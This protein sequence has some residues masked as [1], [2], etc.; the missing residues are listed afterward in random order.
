MASTSATISLTSSNFD[1]VAEGAGFVTTTAAGSGTNQV[2]VP[3][4]ANAAAR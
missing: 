1:T 2:A 4:F 3:I